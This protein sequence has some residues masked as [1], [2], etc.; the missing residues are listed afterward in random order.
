MEKIK[1]FRLVAD[2]GKVLTDGKVKGAVVDV[3][4]NRVQDWMEVEDVDEENGE[5]K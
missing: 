2:D 1:M 4:A 3:L 5:E